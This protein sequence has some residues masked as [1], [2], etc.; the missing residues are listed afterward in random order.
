M[1]GTKLSE[2]IQTPGTKLLLELDRK[3]KNRYEHIQ[4][5]PSRYVLLLADYVA[6]KLTESSDGES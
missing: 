4:D 1:S 6:E 2:L 5:G 3:W